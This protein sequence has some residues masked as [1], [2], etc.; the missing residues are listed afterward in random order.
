MLADSVHTVSFPIH[1]THFDRNDDKITRLSDLKGYT[2]N[3]YYCRDIDE[4]ETNNGGCSLSPFV[5]CINTQVRFS[6][7]T[8]CTQS[9]RYTLFYGGEIYFRVHQN[10]VH[11]HLDTLAMVNFVYEQKVQRIN[12]RIQACAIHRQLVHKHNLEFHVLVRHNTA[13]MDM[14][15]LDALHQVQHQILA[16]QILAIMMESVQMMVHLASVVCVQPVHCHHFVPVPQTFVIRIHVKM[17]V[18]V[19]R[20]ALANTVARVHHAKPDEIVNW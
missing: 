16:Y 8:P 10:A 1:T 9:I 20:R 19:W 4:C 7:N 11:V 14:G 2:G 13:E 12:V 18:L 6:V 15:H 17:E 5:T 3:G